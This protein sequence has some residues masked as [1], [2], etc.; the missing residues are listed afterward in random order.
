MRPTALIRHDDPITEPEAP[1]SKKSETEKL[2]IKR[3]TLRVLTP[4]ELRL[5]GGGGR[6]ATG[7]ANC[8]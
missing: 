6:S 3:E 8:R 7:S 2:T 5:V 1:M 4:A